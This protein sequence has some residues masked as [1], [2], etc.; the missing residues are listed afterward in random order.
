MFRLCAGCTAP[1][2]GLFVGMP[3]R[4]CV[5]YK[6]P[7]QRFSEFSLILLLALAT[8][9]LC[10]HWLPQ[11]PSSY[12]I[13]ATV[14]LGAV[15]VPYI[16]SILARRHGAPLMSREE[17]TRRY[18]A[19]LGPIGSR[20]GAVPAFGSSPVRRTGRRSVRR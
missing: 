2:E 1:R 14:A 13:V 8:A 5:V 16:G 19:E 3:D 10:R 15:L 9:S 4:R 18:L 17:R 11:L 7:F 6:T 12:V 20:A